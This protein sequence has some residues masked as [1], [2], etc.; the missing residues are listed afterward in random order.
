MSILCADSCFRRWSFF[1]I[2]LFLVHQA[3]LGQGSYTAQVRG[4]VTDPAHAVV[5]NV[6][7]T[8]TN[9]LTSIA[10]TATTNDSGEYA[11]NG[12][13]EEHTSELQS[14]CNLVCRLLLE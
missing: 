11:V 6:K 12:R 7:V 10:T 4:T 3:A 5:N 1:L 14:P 13:S 2:V 8:V 9:E